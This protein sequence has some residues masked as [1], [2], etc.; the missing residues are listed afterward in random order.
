MKY[1]KKC[2]RGYSDDDNFCEECG[3][4]LVKYVEYK[5]KPRIKIKLPIPKGKWRW[6]AIGIPTIILIVLILNWYKPPISETEGNKTLTNET[7]G[8]Q[9]R[10][11]QE[12][13]TVQIPYQ[14]NFKYSVV[15]SSVEEKYSLSM[16]VY[17]A[18]VIKLSNEEDKGGEFTVTVYFKVDDTTKTETDSKYIPPRSTETF[19]LIYDNQI[20]QKVTATYSVTPP[21]ETRYREETRYRNVTKCD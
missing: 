19:Q 21:K 4:K 18:V 8:T 14:Y 20:G 12:P 11:V 1:C 9:C 2:R 10:E 7:I 15:D 3:S 16:G 5:E 13:Y 17:T 6:I